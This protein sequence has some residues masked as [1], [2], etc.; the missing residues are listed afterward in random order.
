[1]EI[2]GTPCLFLP[3]A[4]FYFPLANNIAPAAGHAASAVALTITTDVYGG[5]S[6]NRASLGLLLPPP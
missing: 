3:L 1:M 5:E 2:P 6:F 4:S